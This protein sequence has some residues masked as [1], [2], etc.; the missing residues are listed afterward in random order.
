MCGLSLIWVAKK[1]SLVNQGLENYSCGESP[2]GP[3]R[4]NGK[5]LDCAMWHSD[6]SNNKT[7]IFFKE[8]H[9][10]NAINSNI[11]GQT[12]TIQWEWVGR[13]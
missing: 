12:Y 1:Y 5:G 9:D 4:E 13:Y 11:Y 8:P 7:P 2:Y 10:Y 3:K 6:G